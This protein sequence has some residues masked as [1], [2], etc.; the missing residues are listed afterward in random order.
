V[1]I[2]AAVLLLGAG[3]A[4]AAAFHAW[5]GSVEP[6]KGLMMTRAGSID[7]MC[8]FIQAKHSG[9]H[10]FTA[11][12]KGTRIWLAKSPVSGTVTLQEGRFYAIVIEAPASEDFRLKWDQPLGVPMDIPPT[13]LFQPTATVKP[14]C[15]I[16]S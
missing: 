13:V 4:Q 12:A 14:G 15:E 2:L 8:G 3:V 10:N 9:P 7:R 1:K 11:T 6:G 16:L 5:C